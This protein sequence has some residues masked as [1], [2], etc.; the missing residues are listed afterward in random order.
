MER[1]KRPY[2]LQRRP[3][4]KK[5]RFVYYVKFRDPQSGKYRNPVSTGLHT[6]AAA[7]NWADAQLASGSAFAPARKKLRVRDYAETFWDYEHSDYI[8]GKLARGGSIA[9][10]YADISASLT[11]KY[12]IPAFGDRELDSLTPA[13]LEAWI[14][15]LGP[16]QGLS[17]ASVNR[18][19]TCFRVM[20]REAK[21]L[22]L[23]A[24]DP[25]DSVRLLRE[26]SA[27]RGIL[28]P[29]EARLLLAESSLERLWDGKLMAY[30]GNL[31]A[32]AT[33]MRL[34]EVRGLKVKHLR[35]DRVEVL[36]SWEEGYGIKGAKWGSE[37]TV[38]I[39][40]SVYAVL[41]RL[42]P[43]DRKTRAEDFIFSLDG[44]T[45]PAHY[46]YLVA[47]LYEAMKRSGI[48]ESARKERN[49]TFHSWRHFFNSVC[50]GSVS[51]AK[52][53]LV[54]GHRTSEMTERYTHPVEGDLAEIRA[55]QER[56]LKTS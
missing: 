49:L 47:A 44:G 16:K 18:V 25:T 29:E 9:K 2:S 1:A 43:R 22:G 40:P 30:A 50:R 11:R 3:T 14:L 41:E 32:A 37:R 33:G 12:L 53:R 10:A 38:P 8:K 7:A 56:L 48:N 21:R 35:P 24:V 52:L 55:I 31:L 36:H 20:I 4:A 5:N 17:S 23:I 15:S 34:G 26:K 45:K 19:F 51:D 42:L 6:K 13:E 54:T 46:D 39:P 27:V 28:S